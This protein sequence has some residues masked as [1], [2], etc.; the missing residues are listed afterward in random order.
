MQDQRNLDADQRRALATPWDQPVLLLGEAGFGKTTAALHRLAAHLAER[1]GL[2]CLVLVPAPTL[3]P[4]IL[5][6]S[7]SLGLR[8]DVLTVDQWLGDEARVAF[9]ELAAQDSE[10]ATTGVIRLKRHPAVREVLPDIAAGSHQGAHRDDLFDLWGDTRLLAEVVSV[11]DEDLCERDAREVHAHALVQFAEVER[12]ADGSLMRGLGGRPLHVDTPLHD[13][14]TA[15]VEDYPVLFE[16]ERLRGRDRRP[17]RYDHVVLEEAQEF[18]PLELATVAM[19]LRQGSALTVVGDAGQQ[20]DPTAWFAGWDATLTELGAPRCERIALQQSHRCP[21]GIL[22]LSRSIRAGTALPDEAEV[23]RERFSSVEAQRQAL[24]TWLDSQGSAAAIVALDEPAARRLHRVLGGQIP[25]IGPSTR[26]LPRSGG[27]IAL[28][29]QLRG[30]EVPRIAVP[31]LDDA[32]W[33][34]SPHARNTLYLAVT[35]ATES[36]WLSC[37]G[38]WSMLTP[39]RPSRAAS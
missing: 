35:R 25:R 26:R 11:S 28:A 14:L 6:I 30:L 8:P 17:R 23:H 1:P 7:A 39:Q 12:H 38:A 18:A 9:P 34:R 2:A 29:T 13:A 32:R 24:R 31:D 5:R 15:D 19:A 4:K 10:R 33:P 16:L 27:F 37:V 3:V 36:V 22:R 20:V 21:A